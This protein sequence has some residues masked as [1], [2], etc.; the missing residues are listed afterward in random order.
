MVEE[1]ERQM[2]IARAVTRDSTLG[3]RAG[4]MALGGYV[5]EMADEAAA[6]HA[7]LR[8]VAASTRPPEDPRTRHRHSRRGACRCADA[9]CEHRRRDHAKDGPCRLCGCLGFL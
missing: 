2:A 9:R 7:E 4:A 3:E 1:Y 6:L 8:R 5:P